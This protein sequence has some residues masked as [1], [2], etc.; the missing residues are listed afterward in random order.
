MRPAPSPKYPIARLTIV[1]TVC[2]W[3]KGSEFGN[4]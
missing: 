4:D 3:A 2:C 1:M